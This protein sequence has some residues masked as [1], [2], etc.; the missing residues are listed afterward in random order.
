MKIYELMKMVEKYTKKYIG[1]QYKITKGHAT[2]WAFGKNFDFDT[3]F[4][5]NEG[6][7]V[8][9]EYDDEYLVAFS[10][11]VEVEFIC[12]FVKEAII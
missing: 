4:I 2:S 12:K 6:D 11:D 10:P 8:N 9:D 7:F 1:S 3:F 5:S